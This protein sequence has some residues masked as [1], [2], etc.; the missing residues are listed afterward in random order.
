VIQKKAIPPV[1]VF[2]F[3]RP[4]TTAQVF[5]S[6]RA[7]RP[8][9]LFLC[10][11]AP[12]EGAPGDA[13]KCDAV[14]RVFEGVDW[15]CEIFSNY[16]EKNMGCRHRMSS[17]I[18][19]VFEHVEEAIILEDD[20][21]PDQT[22]FRFCAELLERFRCDD[23]VGMIAGHV[24]HLETID[25][26]ESY[27]FDRLNTIWGWATWRRAWCKFDRQMVQWPRFKSCYGLRGICKNA[28]Q[29]KYFSAMFDSVYNN[30]CSSWATAWALTCIRENFLCVHPTSNLISN[31]GCGFD[32]TH[33]RMVDSSWS[34]HPLQ[35]L[36]FP[37]VHPLD[38]MPN[39]AEEQKTMRGLYAT[40]LVDRVSS[41]LKRFLGSEKKK[42]R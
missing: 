3:N 18:S 13:E 5:A 28:Y 34:C 40:P 14:K 39:L 31:I 17:G 29:L 1:A 27:Y 26:Q 6:V 15:P 22:F 8:E 32:A 30:K 19:W 16:A 33:T 10:L 9:K 11:D 37:L 25:V 2:G 23:R 38:T 24:A 4:S 36:T 35:P 7:A 41:R 42:G 21:L 12:R 20:C